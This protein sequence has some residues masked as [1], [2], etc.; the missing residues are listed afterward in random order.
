MCGYVCA[1]VGEGL[2]ARGEGAREGFGMESKCRVG[3]G[4]IE[5]KQNKTKEGKKEKVTRTDETSMA[6]V[7]VTVN[8]SL[9]HGGEASWIT[10]PFSVDR[11]GLNPGG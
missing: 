7:T 5:S 2:A 3:Q 8:D 9:S 10:N 4:I 6:T 1:V 11:F